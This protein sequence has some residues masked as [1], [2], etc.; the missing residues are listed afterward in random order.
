VIRSATLARQIVPVLC[1]SAL[2]YIGI[3]PLLDAVKLYLPSPADVPPI[4]GL[5]PKQRLTA[6]EVR[7]VSIGDP[8]LAKLVALDQEVGH[9]LAA[10]VGGA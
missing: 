4:E 6:L 8:A 1:G 2:D 7:Q 10:S 5:D 9:R 3:Q